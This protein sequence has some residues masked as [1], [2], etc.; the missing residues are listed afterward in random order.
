MLK[1]GNLDSNRVNQIVF[2]DTLE[3]RRIMDLSTCFPN[4]GINFLNTIVISIFDPCDAVLKGIYSVKKQWGFCPQT[5]LPFITAAIGGFLA[6]SEYSLLVSCN[7]NNII[8]SVC[9]T[10]RSPLAMEEIASFQSQ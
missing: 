8:A 10:K 5:P 2:V 4:L 6:F 3:D 7:L 1:L 9:F